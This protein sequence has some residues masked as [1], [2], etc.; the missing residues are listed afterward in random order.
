MSM[1]LSHPP[2][3]MR[4]CSHLFS[5][6]LACGNISNV[7]CCKGYTQIHTC[8]AKRICMVSN[9]CSARSLLGPWVYVPYAH[10]RSRCACATI[11]SSPLHEKFNSET[12]FDGKTIRGVN[13]FQWHILRIEAWSFMSLHFTNDIQYMCVWHWHRC[14]QSIF[15]TVALSLCEHRN[16]SHRYIFCA[17]CFVVKWVDSLAVG[18]ANQTSMQNHVFPFNILP[19]GVEYSFFSSL[20]L[21][22]PFLSIYLSV[23]ACSTIQFI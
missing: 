9:S 23:C 8:T 13:S 19:I 14:P 20:S 1:S 5:I 3:K 16:L 7:N 11:G 4:V 2:S 15:F 18:D 10:S 22:L 21:S 6:Q 17:F 12:N